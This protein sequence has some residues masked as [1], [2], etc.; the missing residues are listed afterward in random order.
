MKT[1]FYIIYFLILLPCI[2]ISQ[3]VE[4]TYKSFKD[5]L[6]NDPVKISGSLSGFGMYYSS[7]NLN[8]TLPYSGRLAAGLQLDVLGIKAPVSVLLSSGGTLFN[9][10]L[11]SYAFIGIS[12]SYK[13]MKL[14]LGSRSLQFDKYSFSGQSFEGLGTELTPGNWIIKS[15]YGKLRRSR[16]EDFNTIQKIEPIYKRYGA[17]LQAGFKNEKDKLLVGLFRA[18]DQKN[19]IPNVDST[20]QFFPSQN[21][22]ISFDAS[23]SLGV[24]TTIKANYAISGLTENVDAAVEIPSNLLRSFAGLLETNVSTRWNQALYAELEQKISRHTL[25]LSYEKVDPGYKSLGAMFFNDDFRNYTL[26]SSLR[27]L[28]NKLL[29]NVRAGLQQNNINGDQI[30]SYNRFIGS[31]NTNYQ[32][33][34]K[35]NISF[36][37]SNFNKVNIR[38][39]FQDPINPLPVSELVIN[40]RSASFNLNATLFNNSKLAS[41]LLCNGN[42]SKG[43][44]IIDDDI[45]FTSSTDSYSGFIYS[46]LDVKNK[47][48]TLGISYNYNSNILTDLSNISQTISFV[49]NKSFA[50][51]KILLNFQSSFGKNELNSNIIE[52]QSAWLSNYS[53]NFNYKISKKT[54]LILSANYL[55]NKARA[56]SSVK[57]FNELRSS[58]N[59]RTTLGKE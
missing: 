29:F 9:Y 35:V 36:E 12:P 25:S 42:Y 11:P 26:G 7:N 57:T 32:I 41:F 37:L 49:A 5:R 14:H 1:V 40:N 38:Y 56:N 17:G 8:R 55:N 48:L 27:F 58:I 34:E 44:S 21:M 6:A 23:K 30:N 4:E 59:F 2:G 33:S 15:F 16:L 39:S 47:A 50:S 51:D 3:D 53:L 18:W 24:K 54:S 43:R 10:E 31:I 28:N 13:W 45:D 19:S 46:G 52:P 22:V 20:L